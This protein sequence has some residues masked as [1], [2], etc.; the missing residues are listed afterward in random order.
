M[1]TKL[2]DLLKK[3][4]KQL[5][6]YI[7]GNELNI[8][9]L[10]D[11]GVENLLAKDNQVL[12][13]FGKD[14]P[15]PQKEGLPIHMKVVEFNHFLAEI[16]LREGSL[17]LDRCLEQR[18]TYE[19]LKTKYFEA[20]IQVDELN[21]LNDITTR[22]E[23]KEDGNYFLP[24]KIA[25]KELFKINNDKAVNDEAIKDSGNIASYAKQTYAIYLSK[26]FKEYAD[27]RHLGDKER[28]FL[29]LSNTYNGQLEESKAEVQQ[30]QS[31]KLTKSITEQQEAAEANMYLKVRSARFQVERNDVSRLVA[32]RRAIQ[33]MT[34]GGALNFQ[35]QMQ[36]IEARLSNDLI[37]AWLRLSAAAKGFN[38]LY[39]YPYSEKLPKETYGVKIDFDELVTWCQYTN[40]WLASFLDTQQIVTCSFSLKELIGLENFND[41]LNKLKWQFNFKTT[42]FYNRKF[43]RMRGLAVQIESGHNAGSW[44]V[45]ITPPTEAITKPED[46][47]HIGTL[48]LGKVNERT[49]A[50]IPEISSPPK[51]YNASPIG[52]GNWNLEILRGSTL[53]V[54]TSGILDIDIHITC[55]LV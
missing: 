27:E 47:S 12:K 36:S 16:L 24:G 4:S 8:Q 30:N 19:E 33:I 49:Y 10:G 5:I 45:A 42:D 37:A 52:K 32:L 55:A 53:G 21:R 6:Q 20:C 34:P 14:F 46:Q 22:E 50:V 51:L 2:A 38:L 1:P 31:K 35:E 3:K 26:H 28:D 43:I 39:Q 44:N 13:R 48:Y 54:S 15:I 9:S 23:D 41:G 7:G 11:Q 29:R 40:T 17:L 18:K 25:T